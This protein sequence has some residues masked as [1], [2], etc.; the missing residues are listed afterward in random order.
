VT[1]PVELDELVEHWT[2]LEDERPLLS[3]KG[4]A[5]LLGT[6]LLLKFSVGHGR[7]PRGR[8]ELPDEVVR[9]VADQVKVP[10]SELGLYDWDGRTIE[11]HR[12]QVRQH[13]GFR[14]CSVEDAEKLAAWL[15]SE[16]CEA[17]R[18]HGRVHEQLLAHCRRGADRAADVG[19]GRPDHQVGA[20][21]G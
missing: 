4:G 17:E 19:P 1:D 7:F 11:R 12:A 9:F 5:G 21:S 14:E 6:A 13:L 3:G 10:A 20:E 8:S 15:A 18:D 2:L 16:V